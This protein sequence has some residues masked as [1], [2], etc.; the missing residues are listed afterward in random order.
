MRP[1]R[2]EQLAAA[3]MRYV[4]GLAVLVESLAAFDAQARFETAAR[5]VK[6]RV[7]DLGVARR[8]LFADR[9]VLLEHDNLAAGEGKLARNRETNGAG[10]DDDRVSTVVHCMQACSEDE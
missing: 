9:G 5:I 8:G 10:A 7:D 1:S 4:P 3:P 2:D 6:A